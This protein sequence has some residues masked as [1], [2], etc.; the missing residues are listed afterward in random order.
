MLKTLFIAVCIISFS[1]LWY[2]LAWANMSIEKSYAEQEAWK[3][4][5]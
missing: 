1:M 3:Q 2:S 4:L 5:Q